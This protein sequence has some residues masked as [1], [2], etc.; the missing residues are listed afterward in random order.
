MNINIPV[1]HLVVMP[2]GTKRFYSYLQ[3]GA[4]YNTYSDTSGLV[5]PCDLYTAY[6]LGVVPEGDIPNHLLAWWKLTLENN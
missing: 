2:N 3:Q 5:I 1:S 4:S 6:K